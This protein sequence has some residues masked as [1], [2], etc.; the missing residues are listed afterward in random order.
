MARKEPYN[1]LPRLVSHL[2]S[3]GTWQDHPDVVSLYLTQFE[4]P[5]VPMSL[6]APHS[7]ID[8]MSGLLLAV[9]HNNSDC[10]RALESAWKNVWKWMPSIYAM[11]RIIECRTARAPLSALLGI[12]VVLLGNS[13]VAPALIATEG[14][15]GLAM[16]MY[17]DLGTSSLDNDQDIQER[18]H[19][20][21]NALFLILKSPLCGAHEV[22]ETVGFSPRR[23]AR[24]LLRPIHLSVHGGAA[25][26][27]VFS[28]LLNVHM[29]L[30]NRCP[31]FYQSLPAQSVISHL[32]VAM[33]RFTSD[34]F[35]SLTMPVSGSLYVDSSP[36]NIMPIL[37]FWNY[38]SSDA[39]H[40]HAWIIHAL[41][42]G[43]VSLLLKISGIQTLKPAMKSGLIKLIDDLRAYSIH[44]PVVRRLQQE[45]ALMQGIP[46][47]DKKIVG[48]WRL[49]R[50][51]VN[52]ANIT[53]TEFD[54]LKRYTFR[55]QYKKCEEDRLGNLASET[56]G[57]ATARSAGPIATVSD[58]ACPVPLLSH[59]NHALER[60]FLVSPRTPA[61]FEFLVEREMSSHQA[62]IQSKR[63]TLLA[64]RLTP[65]P[66]LVVFDYSLGAPPDVNV[67]YEY[68]NGTYRN[69][70]LRRVPVLVP[71]I[72]VTYGAETER[73]VVSTDISGQLFGW[74]EDTIIGQAT[75]IG[76][77]GTAPGYIR[78]EREATFGRIV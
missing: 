43:L 70:G 11:L 35:D 22:A 41:R 23:A 48:A 40:G 18:A 78:V 64:T 37:V 69:L 30:V 36:S 51:A 38:Y 75:G 3:R 47:A 19:H 57:A 67:T 1:Y 2:H 17:I 25:W 7:S 55:C 32:C 62:F 24:A 31:A 28:V 39:A 61:F 65:P 63:D 33:S 77:R 26:R 74:L 54:A 73:F 4:S 76:V 27:S 34:Y 15:L 29:E 59:I 10:T 60:D 8:A 5:P 9:Q 66:Y 49:L 58:N 46:T 20:I 21:S 42:Y 68:D 13:T 52:Y 6:D 44:R 45:V 72:H 16:Q 12:L 71:Q 14:V 56:T 50:E 53:H